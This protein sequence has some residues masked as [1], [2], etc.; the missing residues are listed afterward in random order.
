MYNRSLSR[1]LSLLSLG[2]IKDTGHLEL[3]KI[4]ID[5]IFESALDSLINH[6]RDELDNCEADLENVSQHILDS[7]L[8]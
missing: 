8:K 4:Q 2:L 3:N 5:E 6:C 1:E 7:E